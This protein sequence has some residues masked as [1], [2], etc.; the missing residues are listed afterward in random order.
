MSS[1]KVETRVNGAVFEIT[2]NRPERRNALDLESVELLAEALQAADRGPA[3][4]VVLQ[5]AGGSFCSGADLGEFEERNLKERNAT[6]ARFAAAF[7]EVCSRLLRLKI[8]VIAAMEGPALGGGATLALHA[9]F[10]LATD[11]LRIGIPASKLGIVLSTPLVE[12][13]VNVL[14]QQVSA[15]LLL[16]GREFAAKEAHARGIVDEIVASSEDLHSRT[17]EIASD[18]E[19]CDR[20]AVGAHK[21]AINRVP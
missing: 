15:D 2:F 17:M 12:R 19:A 13:I 7:D 20:D 18:I 5:G 9:D 3:R 21:R 16:R 10:R 14:G 6:M 8:P 4:V 1:R 11:N